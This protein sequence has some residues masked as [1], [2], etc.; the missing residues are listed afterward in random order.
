MND[1]VV[2]KLN[3]DHFNEYKNFIDQFPY[4]MKAYFRNKPDDQQIQEL[5]ENEN[6][7]TVAG[8]KDNQIIAVL[9]GIFNSSL[10]YWFAKNLFVD[11]KSVG[12]G[13]GNYDESIFLVMDLFNPLIRYGESR[14]IYSFYTRKNVD[15][16]L[17]YEKVVQRLRKRLSDEKINQY[18]MLSYEVFYERIYAKEYFNSETNFPWKV[19]Y[20]MGRPADTETIIILHTLNQDERKKILGLI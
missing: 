16:Q 6:V 13:L 8:F 20:G 4:V 15:H 5:L 10:P 17:S 19:Y 9:T 2:Q 7:V 12:S 3:I 11:T 14:R 18:R 1:I